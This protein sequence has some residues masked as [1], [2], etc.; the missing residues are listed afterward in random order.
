MTSL[1]QIPLPE[2]PNALL[3]Y[4]LE[5]GTIDVIYRYGRPISMLPGGQL[6]IATDG[7]LTRDCYSGGCHYGPCCERPFLNS[8]ADTYFTAANACYHGGGGGGPC[9]ERPFLSSSAD[10]YFSKPE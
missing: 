5:G 8:S 1:D 6:V 4:L 10:E 2:K 9:C 7:L 3:D